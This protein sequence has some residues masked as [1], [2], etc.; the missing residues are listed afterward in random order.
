[1]RVFDFA[2]HPGHLRA[3][4]VSPDGRIIATAGD[5]GTVRFW[6]VETGRAGLV[7][8]GH[9]GGAF[10][11]AFD[12]EGQKVATLGWDGV[13]RLWDVADGAS[14]GVFRGTVQHK[15]TS[16]FGNALAFDAAGRRLAADERR[17][18]GPRLG[19]RLDRRLPLILRGHSKEV[20]SVLFGPGA[21][22]SSP[23]RRTRRSSSG[24]PHRRGG[25]HPP[26]PHRR[27][28]RDRH[29][30]RRPPDRLDRH[31]HHGEALGRASAPDRSRPIDS[32]L[33][34]IST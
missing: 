4:A 14:L 32:I 29:Q 20:N 31:R 24:T 11:V 23:P 13:V 10:A 5:D 8:G 34:I 25:L 26:R 22:G 7:L 12:P 28:P 2:G 18:H 27:G 19:P 16:R 6:D 3:V 1:M 30:P 33:S 15:S 21:G 9:D 17:R